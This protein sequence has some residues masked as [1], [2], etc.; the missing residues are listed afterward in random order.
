MRRLQVFYLLVFIAL[1]GCNHN[2]YAIIVLEGHTNIADTLTIREIST[3][4]VIAQ[5]PLIKGQSEF[6]F[7]LDEI[8]IASIELNGVGNENIYVID[9]KI[10]KVINIDSAVLI[11][12][13]SVADS[14][15]KYFWRSQ[16]EMFEKHNDLFWNE[17]NP[18]KV[19]I[20]FDSLISFRDQQ[21]TQMMSRLSKDEKQLLRSRNKG[22]AYNFLFYYGRVIR[23]YP[24]ETKYYEFITNIDH[25]HILVKSMPDIVLYKYE[26]EI[27]RAIDT[28][29]GID[30]FLTHIDKQDISQ[31]LR[32]FLKAIYLQRIIDRPSYWKKHQ[33]FITKAAFESALER[34]QANDYLHLFKGLAN[35]F[36]SSRE[37]ER[38]FDFSAIANNGNTVKLSDF[39]GKLVVIGVWATWCAP[40]LD[41]RP[42]LV[43]IADKY[44]GNSDVVILLISVDQSVK[45]WKTFLNKEIRAHK[46]I[47]VIIPDGMK[48]EFGEKYLIK[49]IPKY[50][51]INE[52]GLII[53]VDLP[54][55]SSSLDM[56][57]EEELRFRSIREI[58]EII[59]FKA[60]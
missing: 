5:I 34:E 58:R 41:E 42:H 3:E 36:I 57:I 12:T 11:K 20:V 37:G 15:L 19:L 24:C 45:S 43:E 35:S 39:K 55:P 16:N 25:D 44:A 59:G 2:Q 48:T 10:K 17:N 21:I 22:L 23:E 49:I 30:H 9:P 52:N 4:K 38:A 18:E 51:M 6:R 13:N 33:Y 31:D 32:D 40:C 27:L 50:I 28:I 7:K 14:L 46:G 56:R 26:V 29:P 8:I 54:K 53:D 60:F 1:I 47:D